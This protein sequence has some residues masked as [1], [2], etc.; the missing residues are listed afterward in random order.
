MIARVTSRR[1]RDFGSA[2]SINLQAKNKNEI[3]ESRPIKNNSP[4]EAH[5]KM[6]PN[7]TNGNRKI[8]HILACSCPII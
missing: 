1:K 2:V 7:V 8:V 4:V 6:V 5:A 3:M